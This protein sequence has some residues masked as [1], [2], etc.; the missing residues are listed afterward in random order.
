MLN[1][2]T[3]EEKRLFGEV[4]E[5]V[6]IRIEGRAYRVPKGLELLRCFQFLRFKIA[7]ENF[8]W[9][10]SCENCAANIRLPGESFS[11]DL[12]CQRT[13]EE[14]V[15]IETLPAGIRKLP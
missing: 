3:D 2:Q 11:R 8:C 15:E 9:N 7:F 12:C 6:E 10:A 4:E 5:W 1:Q 14:G 13:A